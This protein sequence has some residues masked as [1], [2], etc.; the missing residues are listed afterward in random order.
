MSQK[1]LVVDDDLEILEM[2]YDAL[3]DEGYLVYKAS[4]SFEARSQL[5]VN[6]DLMILDVMMPGQ[7][8]FEFCKEIRSVVSCPIIFL[9]AKV[10]ESDLIQGFAI[11]GDDYLTKPFSLRE[12]RARVAAHLRRNERQSSREQS[13]LIFQHLKIILQSRT[14]LYFDECVPLTKRE[15]E[16]V[17]LLALNKNQVFSKEQIYELVWGLDAEGDCATVA[18]HV[19]KVRSKFQT[20]QTDFNYLKT[21]WGVGYKWD[22]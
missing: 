5:K 14:V 2:L 21:V 6:P 13:F 22:V 20:I 19:K 15:Y 7:D 11:G 9:T 16:I 8:G 1:I 17:E 12:L 3:N 10:S 4:N 18:E